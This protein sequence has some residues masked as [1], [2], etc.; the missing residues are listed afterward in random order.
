[1]DELYKDLKKYG[2]VRINELLS[3]HT[4]FKI[5][6]PV[7]YFVEIGDNESL[8]ACLGYLAG[9]G[10]DFFVIGGGANVLA[11]DHGYDGVIVAIKTSKINIEG[12]IIVADAGV[13]LSEVVLAA[14]KN[15]L[16]GLEWAVGIPGTIGGAVRGNA[17][18]YGEEIA[19]SV[20]KVEAWVDG[21][22]REMSSAECDFGYRTSFFKE[23][24]GIIMRIWIKLGSADRLEIAEKMQEI[25]S[26]RDSKIPK[27][28]SAGSFFKNIKVSDWP[29]GLPE[30][31]PGQFVERG[32]IPVGWLVEES[33]LKGRSF[34][35]A[36]ISESHGN[37][38][39]N[40]G[41]ASQKDVLDLVETVINQVYNKFGVELEPE[42]KILS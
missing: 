3:K 1:M 21:E 32:M 13:K 35:D 16:G 18:A 25:I 11:P 9:N 7:K 38:I 40:K 31:L 33:G 34:G 20:E 39:I 29:G 28:P 19:A 6:G 5:G 8:E 2:K 30:N 14:S 4:T 12:N 27:E 37:V 22:L 26:K 41:K 24:G 42:V 17:G 23:R 15:S 10:I 36:A